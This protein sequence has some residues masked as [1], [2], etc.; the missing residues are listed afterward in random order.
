MEFA[1]LSK[2]C[3]LHFLE[4]LTFSQNQHLMTCG[5]SGNLRI[6][7][8]PHPAAKEGFPAVNS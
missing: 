6:P 1:G 3:G 5:I 8:V 4:F 7:E 2:D